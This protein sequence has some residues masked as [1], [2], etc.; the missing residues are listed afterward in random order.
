[1]NV[2]VLNTLLLKLK[3]IETDHSGPEEEV[4]QALMYFFIS[5]CS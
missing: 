5:K 3:V 2:Q 1:M 4:G